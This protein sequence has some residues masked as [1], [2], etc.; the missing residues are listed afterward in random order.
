MSKGPRIRSGGQG[1]RVLEAS[2]CVQTGRGSWRRVGRGELCPGSLGQD[3]VPAP[4]NKREGVG[5]G[6]V[7]RRCGGE[8]GKNSA[9]F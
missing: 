4:L 6:A 7:R 5:E 8:E 1:E 9:M 3:E 2:G